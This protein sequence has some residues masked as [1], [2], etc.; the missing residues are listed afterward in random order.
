MSVESSEISHG[1]TFS[2]RNFLKDAGTYV[3]GGL[4]S[5]M[6]LTQTDERPR[7]ED[8]LNIFSDE[9]YNVCPVTEYKTHYRP[10]KVNVLLRT[11]LDTEN[12]YYFAYLDWKY[13]LRGTFYVRTDFGKDSSEGI[14]AYSI[15]NKNFQ[16]FY[17]NLQALGFEMGLHFTAMAECKTKEVNNCAKNHFKEELADLR[18]AFD[19]KSV[20]A[21]GEGH[22]S[23]N[24]YNHLLTD[25]PDWPA[26]SKECG[27]ISADKLPISEEISSKIKYKNLADCDGDI[28]NGKI[29]ILEYF[30]K[31][32]AELKPGDIVQVLVHPYLPRWQMQLYDNDSPP[33][34]SEPPTNISEMSNVSLPAIFAVLASLLFV[35]LYQRKEKLRKYY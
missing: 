22:L 2:R 24:H 33:S 1:R 8:F 28:V 23:Y 7:Y 9:K 35:K 15:D 34:L 12:G 3:A 17:Q 21:H 18:K 30:E 29:K 13:G 32:L 25:S 19:V 16:E 27:V 4:T 6:F 26:L 31:G 20:A 10:D 14:V 5:L 11:D